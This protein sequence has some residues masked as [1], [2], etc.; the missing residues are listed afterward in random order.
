MYYTPYV[1]PRR[2]ALI[3]NEIYCTLRWGNAIV[4][5]DLGMNCLSLIDPPSPN[6]YNR[7]LALMLMEDSSLGFAYIEGSNLYLWSRK[8]NSEGA[9]EWV[10]CRVIELEGMIPAADPDDEAYVVGFA[11]GVGV[12]FVSTGVGLFTIKLNSGQVKEVDEPG[13]HFSVLPYLSFYTPSP[14]LALA[15]LLTVIMHYTDSICF[16]G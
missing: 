2:G 7:Y 6:R 15:Y 14:V 1:Q 5:Y 13:V 12:I 11:E 8:V 16:F 3:G 10:Q 9:A 4:K